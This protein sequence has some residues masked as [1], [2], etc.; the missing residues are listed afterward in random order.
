MS[1]G[2]S[3]QL[4][5]N[6]MRATLRIEAGLSP[7]DVTLEIAQAAARSTGLILNQGVLDALQRGIEAWKAD[8]GTRH[9]SVIA[10]GTPPQHGRNGCIE[11]V[12]AY[13]PTQPPPP[14]ADRA[15]EDADEAIDFYAQSKYVTVRAGTQIATLHD[16]VAGVDGVTVL[17]VA[18]AAS[19]GKP[20]KLQTDDSIIIDG[21]NR[22]VAARTGLI[23][24]GERLLRILDCLTI[25]DYVDFHTGHVN[26]DGSVVVKKG[27][28][29]CFRVVCTGNLEVHGLIEAAEIEVGGN[30]AFSR[31]VAGRDKG[32][33]KV[34]DTLQARYLN[35]ITGSIGRDLVVEREIVGCN[36][37]VGRNLI[38]KHGHLVGG[39]IR[40]G[41]K[42]EIDVVGSD[43]AVPTEVIVGEVPALVAVAQQIR[44]LRAELE[45]K[46]KPV[47]LR[48]DQLA[49]EQ[50]RLNARQKEELCEIQFEMM[51]FQRNFKRLD[52]KRDE[53]ADRMRKYGRT[54]LIVNKRIHA[55]AMLGLGGGRYYLRADL[56]GPLQLTLNDRGEPIVIDLITKHSREL[57]AVADIA[58][59]FGDDADAA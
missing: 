4:G 23:H 25:D 5:S 53:I 45:K 24:F 34:G 38:M 32:R 54:D 29:D 52:D 10:E 26:F 12:P 14:D 20:L 48:Y 49:A 42:A 58:V 40:V 50:S 47:Q 19:D 9:I 1:D 46:A 27:I 33:V 39:S 57:V 15:A 56:R 43:A 28:R 8:P 31:G 6:K 30:A 18:V 36:L 17:G 3:V 21:A 35:G 51:E 22:V 13:D 41:Q 7:D 11:W 55:K 16:P 44:D 2:I 37:R 59:D